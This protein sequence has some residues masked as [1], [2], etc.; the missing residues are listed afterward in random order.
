MCPTL[1]TTVQPAA[2]SNLTLGWFADSQEVLETTHTPGN[3]NSWTLFM[4]NVSEAGG[5]KELTIT[6]DRNGPPSFFRV[7]KN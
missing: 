6:V 5:Y 1:Y 7:R 3:P 4:G 2:S